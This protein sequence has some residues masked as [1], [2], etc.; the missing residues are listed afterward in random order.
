MRPDVYCRCRPVRNKETL[1]EALE[2]R[3][4]GGERSGGLRSRIEYFKNTRSLRHTV[5]KKKSEEDKDK[6]GR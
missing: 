6:N 5:A 3:L 1:T 2:R 4:E